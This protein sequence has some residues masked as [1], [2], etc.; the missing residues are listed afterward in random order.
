MITD[1]QITANVKCPVSIPGVTF[2]H[3]DRFNLQYAD[4]VLASD[5]DSLLPQSQ[6]TVDVQSR[7]ANYKPNGH[8]HTP[9]GFTRLNV[10]QLR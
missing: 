2:F 3:I 10:E 8:I 6:V 4:A 7:P 5:L 1:T 9:L